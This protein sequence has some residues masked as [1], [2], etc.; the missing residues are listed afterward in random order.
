MS[1]RTTVL[2]THRL[3]LAR[4]ADRVIVIRDGRIAQDGAPDELGARPG[5]FR[6]IFAH[7]PSRVSGR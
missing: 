6:E 3:D 1:G 4:R 5:P 2:I 7:G